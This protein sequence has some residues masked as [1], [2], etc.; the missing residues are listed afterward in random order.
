MTKGY[1]LYSFLSFFIFILLNNFFVNTKIFLTLKSLS[2]LHFY[3]FGLF[4]DWT[5]R[6]IP[7]FIFSFLAFLILKLVFIFLIIKYLGKRSELVND[8]IGIYYSFDILASILIILNIFTSNQ[9]EFYFFSSAPTF[10]FSKSLGLHTSITFL[11]MYLLSL[12]THNHTHKITKKQLLSWFII[13]I[14]SF[15]FSITFFYIVRFI[16]FE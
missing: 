10:N 2:S 11:F 13:S 8:F 15:S 7:H 5:P 6:I 3:L 16:V 1:I 9:P 12:A 14:I 4:C